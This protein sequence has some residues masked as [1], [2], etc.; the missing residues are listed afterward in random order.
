MVE[1]IDSNA[2]GSK[3][4]EDLTDEENGRHGGNIPKLRESPKTSGYYLLLETV[5]R[6][7]G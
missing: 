5:G 4:P 1:E 7:H 6:E 3:E 2:Q